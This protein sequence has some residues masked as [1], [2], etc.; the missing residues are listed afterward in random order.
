MIHANNKN[1]AYLLVPASSAWEVLL[2]NIYKQDLS[3]LWLY[4]RWI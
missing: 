1:I 2:L 3:T 4:F